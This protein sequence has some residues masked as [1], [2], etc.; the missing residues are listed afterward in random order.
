MMNRIS[1]NQMTTRRW[2]MEKDFQA[3]DDL[4]LKNIGLWR[5]KYEELGESETA[6]L[7]NKFKVNVSSISWVGGFT[8]SHGYLIDDCIRE[9][10]QVIR[11]ASWVGAKTVV[12]ATGEQ[13]KHIFSY[14]QKLVTDS[15]MLLGDYAKECNVE[16][17]VMPMAP[18]TARGWTFL[19]SLKKTTEFLK[20]CDHPN[21]G[22]CLH[23]YHALQDSQWKQILPQL[24][25]HIKL[26]K[27]C[28]GAS[29][30]RPR[31]QC[32]P[33][34]GKMN[35]PGLFETLESHNYQGLY[36]ID[37]W[38]EQHWKSNQTDQLR[39]SLNSIKDWLAVPSS[40]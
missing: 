9:A 21:I 15:L 27:L 31:K 26:V 4:G 37:T 39:S 30:K 33:G 34:Q 6:N 5:L 29:P 19:T 13:D 14:A 18:A 25:P 2:S 16:L 3:I 17:A 8:G 22:L 7:I 12:V 38:C 40:K 32:L 24:I 11:F 1:L 35:L 10:V 23:S 28:D 36:E 20:Q